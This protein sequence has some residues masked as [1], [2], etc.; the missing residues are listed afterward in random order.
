MD[1]TAETASAR[2]VIKMIEFGALYVD[3]VVEIV[4]AALD[5]LIEAIVAASG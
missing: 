4:E 1:R 2:Y 3:A 5:H